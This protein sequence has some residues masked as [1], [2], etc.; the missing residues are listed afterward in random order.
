MKDDRENL[1]FN[2]FIILLSH[3]CSCDNTKD[4]YFREDVR[5]RECKEVWKEINYFDKQNVYE[6]VIPEIPSLLIP[7]PIDL[8]Y[9]YVIKHYFAPLTSI[10]QLT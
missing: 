5:D 7:I 1:T 4:G 3:P 2:L 10:T 8:T 6:I 9:Y